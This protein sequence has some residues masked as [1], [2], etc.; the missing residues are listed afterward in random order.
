MTFNHHPRHSM[1]HHLRRTRLPFCTTL[2]CLLS[3]WGSDVVAQLPPTPRET[4]RYQIPQPSLFVSQRVKDLGNILA[5][6]RPAITWR[7]ENQGKADLIIERTKTSC[8][9]TVVML[10]EEEKIIPP[11]EYLDLIVEFNSTGRSGPQS[12]VISIYSNDPAEPVLK[13]EFNTTINSMYLID[14][15]KLMNLRSVRRGGKATRTID[16]LPGPGYHHINLIEVTTPNGSPLL[17]EHE[18][19]DSNDIL[20]GRIHLHIAE[21]AP[22]GALMSSVTIKFLVDGVER[23]HEV[24]IRGDIVGDLTWRPREISTTRHPIRRGHRLAPVTLRS[25]ESIPFEIISAHAGPM[26]DVVYQSRSRGKKRGNYSVILTLREDAPSGPFGT[27]LVIQTD[28]LDQPI[29]EIPVFGVVSSSLE[30][31]PPIVLL[32]QDGTLRGT[33]R[34]VKIKSPPPTSL[35]LSSITCDH[36]GISVELDQQVVARYPHFQ[37]LMVRLRNDLPRGTHE[38]LITFTT[39]VTGTERV[40]IPVLIDAP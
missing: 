36:P 10:T 25:T 14:P 17:L 20:G 37:F 32:R 30:I 21:T 1:F 35:T 26:F 31:D 39:N 23:V 2:L 12:K 16:L 40:Q 4:V 19:F 28:V 38:A 34:R 8:G 11:G 15:P 6:D 5:G 22:L 33:Q 7:L 18:P 9:C 29:V 24:P 13:L 3:L 27:M